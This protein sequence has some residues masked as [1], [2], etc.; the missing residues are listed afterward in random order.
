MF[1]Q[2]LI[3]ESRFYQCLTVVEC[4][5]HFERGNILSQCSELFFLY[6][7]DFS[8]RIEH[9]H[10]NTF[11]PQKAVS[12]SASRITGSSYQHIDILLS[13]FFNEVPQQT[14]HETT[15]YI[16]ERQ[17]GTMEKFEGINILRYLYQRYIKTQSIIYNLLQRF[18]RNVFS[19]ESIGHTI[20]YLLKRQR[21]NR[22]VKLL[23]KRFDGHRHE[24]T[25]VCGKAFN[26]CFL[27][28]SDRSLF[29]GTIIFHCYYFKFTTDYT[30]SH[31]LEITRK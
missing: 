28:R 11:H 5:V 3:H 22:I 27:Q 20:R 19:K 16:F 10:M 14:C 15:A 26:D 13:F 2:L 25:F 17:S 12:N 6:L 7:T 1:I 31:R 21:I 30:D 29:I 8:F 4:S 18:C 9:I 23:R 24:Q